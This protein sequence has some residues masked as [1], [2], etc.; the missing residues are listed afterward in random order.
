M[1]NDYLQEMPN[2]STNKIRKSQGGKGNLQALEDGFD[3][4]GNN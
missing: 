3:F 2:Y 1:T 4:V